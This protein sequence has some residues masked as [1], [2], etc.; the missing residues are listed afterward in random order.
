MK[1]A[2]LQC[3]IAALGVA[4]AARAAPASQASVV[5]T[6]DAGLQSRLE[7]LA[8]AV[9]RAQ[10]PEDTAAILVVEIKSRAALAALI[11]QAES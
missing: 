9:S 10:G 5:S 2:L 3:W 8:A 7:P 4:G 11:T 6:I 1:V